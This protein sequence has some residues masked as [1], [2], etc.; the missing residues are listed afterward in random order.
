M[1]GFRSRSGRSRPC[2]LLHFFEMVKAGVRYCAACDKEVTRGET[3]L[4][5]LIER[6]HIP[7]DAMLASSGFTVDALG[8]I[9]LDICRDC[10]PGTR[11]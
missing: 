3:C 6:D 2:F 8:N 11:M 1:F 4:A 7:P 9:R 5:A 10:R